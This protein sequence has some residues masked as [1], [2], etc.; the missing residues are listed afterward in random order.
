ME[1]AEASG[2]P[3]RTIRFYIARGILPAPRQVGRKAANDEKH[4]E[5]LRQIT[6]LKLKGL[7]LAEIATKLGPKRPAD[8][9]VAPSHV[10]S[11]TLSEDVTV[12]VRADIPPWRMNTIR[13]ILGHFSAQLRKE[14]DG[15]ATES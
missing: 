15:D 2:I 12:F 11:F 8:V 1:L 7:T 3:P 13:R 14:V 6:A 4:F 5:R 10:A 9:L